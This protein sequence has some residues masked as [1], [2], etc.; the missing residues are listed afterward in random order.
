M[1]AA[2][3]VSDELTAEQLRARVAELEATLARGKSSAARHSKKSVR[4]GTPDDPVD[5]AKPAHRQQNY[6]SRE[7]IALGGEIDLDPMSEEVF[8]KVV[9]A[10]RY[11]TEEQDGLRQPWIA[12]R[13]HLNPAGGL[14]VQAWEK[15][16]FEIE[17]GNVDRA[18]WVGF[19]AEQLG[20]LAD[21]DFHPLDFSTLVPRARIDF[22]RDDGYRGSPG[23][24]NFLTGFNIPRDLF[25]QAFA[26]LGKIAHG[27]FAV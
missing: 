24:A 6:L 18:I 10:A 26:G 3:V 4:W 8:N 20:L 19:S 25:D 2:R 21:Q 16:M 9:R 27:Q 13:L 14:V 15:L 17:H 7:R 11:F 5:P 23:H 1:A 12:E 22:E